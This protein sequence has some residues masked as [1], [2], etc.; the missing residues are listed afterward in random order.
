MQTQPHCN[1]FHLVDVYCLRFLPQ[2]IHTL[3]SFLLTNARACI[4]CVYACHRQEGKKTTLKFNYVFS[5]VQIVYYI[6][7]CHRQREGCKMRTTH[8]TSS[9]LVN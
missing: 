7:A 2:S 4:Q 9:E 8:V 1:A 5:S 3:P 6:H